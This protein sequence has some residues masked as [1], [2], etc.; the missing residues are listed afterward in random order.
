MKRLL[1]KGTIEKLLRRKDTADVEALRVEH[2]QLSERK[3]KLASDWALG[4][5]D[6]RHVK[7]ANKA[8][9][10]RMAQIAAT[11]AKVGWLSPLELLAC[12]GIRKTWAKLSMEQ[13][14]VILETVLATRVVAC[15]PTT[16]DSTL[17]MWR[18]GG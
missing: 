12:K 6:D 13:K 8:I 7:L 9:D 10:D 17:M 2:V 18:P 1:G 3:D 15:K 16:A 11:L 5:L 14:R 4:A